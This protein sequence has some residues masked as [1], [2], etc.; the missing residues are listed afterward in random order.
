[1]Q[2]ERISLSYVFAFQKERLEKN[3]DLVPRLFLFLFQKEKR[4]RLSVILSVEKREDAQQGFSFS[5][6][7]FVFCWRKEEDFR[8]CN[9]K[10]KASPFFSSFFI[11]TA[12]GADSFSLFLRSPFAW[13]T[14]C[15]VRF[16][17]FLSLFLFK[18]K[19][20]RKERKGGKKQNNAKKNPVWCKRRDM[21]GYH[22]AHGK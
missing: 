16:F 4:K 1:M 2:K 21:E 7:F 18:Q 22:I 14:S 3:D 15:I 6:L 19:A 20:F 12:C 9:G 8:P 17:F 11:K 5:F 13:M 10:R